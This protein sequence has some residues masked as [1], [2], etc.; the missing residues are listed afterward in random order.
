LAAALAVS[1]QYQRMRLAALGDDRPAL[2]AQ[3]GRN[4][5]DAL[6]GMLAGPRDAI[7]LPRAATRE[8]VVQHARVFRRVFDWPADWAGDLI[9]ERPAIFERDGNEWKFKEIGILA[10]SIAENGVVVE[11]LLVRGVVESSPPVAA[12]PLNS[13]VAE[14]PVDV[15]AEPPTPLAVDLPPALPAAEEPERETV[16]E[17]LGGKNVA[18]T[19]EVADPTANAVV[20]LPTEVA[21]V[22]THDAEVEQ[23][24]KIVQAPEHST[25]PHVQ[26]LNDEAAEH[27]E[28]EAGAERDDVKANGDALKDP[29]RHPHIQGHLHVASALIVIIGIMAVIAIWLSG[30]M[31]PPINNNSSAPTPA[32]SPQR[33]VKTSV[34]PTATPSPAPTPLAHENMKYFPPGS[35]TAG[36]ADG[37]EFER[38]AHTA[39]I[40]KG[41]YLDIK[42]VTCGQYEAYLTT[43]PD[44]PAPAGW[45]GR[46]C[47][48]GQEELPVTGVGWYGAKDYAESKGMRLPTEMEWEYAAR[49]NTGFLYPWGNEWRPDAVNAG[50]SQRYIAPADSYHEGA[51]AAGLLHMSGNVWEW[52]SSDFAAYEGGQL[53]QHSRARGIVDVGGKVIRGGAWNSGPQHATTTYRMG[54]LPRDAGDYS[55]TG[56]RCAKD[57]Q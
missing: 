46:R 52:T 1:D 48:A 39:T 27:R 36:R 13:V 19:I 8:K 14:P 50:K 4:G 2:V 18:G 35:F 56:F 20:G 12:E 30:K 47:P 6:F 25:G 53:P 26:H 31:A 42:E 57:E 38:P 7:V 49:W 22:E 51:T 5:R 45:R 55:N 28:V 16:A 3:S 17:E 24:P 21:A 32:V 43:R 11:G 37:T 54:Y 10:G 15:A 33:G 34:T 23:Q 9:V 41:F 40:T 44:A 29:H